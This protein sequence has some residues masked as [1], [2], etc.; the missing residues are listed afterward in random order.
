MS[1]WEWLR[2]LESDWVIPIVRVAVCIIVILAVM[3][4]VLEQRDRRGRL[5]RRQ[6]AEKSGA[7]H[8]NG[9]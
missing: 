1:P 9:K 6:W 2:V 8:Y 3:F 4:V 7:L 5:R